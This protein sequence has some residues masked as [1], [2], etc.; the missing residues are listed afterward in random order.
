MAFCGSSH[1]TANQS[2]IDLLIYYT[3]FRLVIIIIGYVL[4]YL[5][6]TRISRL[7]TAVVVRT[8]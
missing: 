4:T 3:T 7:S 1:Y 8:L 2:A 6:T 5:L